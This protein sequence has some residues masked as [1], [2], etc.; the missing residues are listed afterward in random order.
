MPKKR[1]ALILIILLIVFALPGCAVQEKSTLVDQSQ[2][3]Y[4]MYIGL[5]D[6]DTYKQLISDDEALKIVSEICLKYVDGYT[7]TKRQG[8]YKDDKGIVTQENSLV[9]EFYLAT[10]E[11]IK[12]I[13]DETL[14]KL[15]QNSILIE[16]AKVDY[17]FYEGATKK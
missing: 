16:K 11:Q 4:H 13:M 1:I 8:G 6:K 15:N 10:D 5:N 12:S 7:V 2:A 14:V 17:K 9:Y 3:K